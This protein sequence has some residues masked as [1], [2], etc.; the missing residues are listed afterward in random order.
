MLDAIGIL[1]LKSDLKIVFQSEQ[2]EDV[3]KILEEL[4]KL[5]TSM[6]NLCGHCLLG[7]NNSINGKGDA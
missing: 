7:T 3:N 6:F 1:V 4:K 2:P 5:S